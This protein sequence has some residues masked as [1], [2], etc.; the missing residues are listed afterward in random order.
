MAYSHF[1]LV[2]FPPVSHAQGV[3]YLLKTNR[4]DE[5]P[6]RKYEELDKKKT[7]FCTRPR[8]ASIL[9]KKGYPC[10]TTV[11]PFNGKTAWIFERSNELNAIIHNYLTQADVK[12]HSVI[13]RKHGA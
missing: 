4:K 13:E 11:N 1:T 3:F 2:L 10:E 6:M 9:M 7:Y 12:K 8:L 5:L